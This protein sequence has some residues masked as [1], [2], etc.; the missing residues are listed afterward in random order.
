MD[1]S[2]RSPMPYDDKMG[3]NDNKFQAQPSV[4]MSSLGSFGSALP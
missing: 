3:Q 2:S 4:P 1:R